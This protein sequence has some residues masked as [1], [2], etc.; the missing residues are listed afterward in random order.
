MNIENHA[1]SGRL[2]R[3]PEVMAELG[4]GLTKVYALI[5]AGSLHAVKLGRRTLV[6]EES[7]AT[8]KAALPKADIRTGRRTAA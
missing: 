2:L 8:F 3:V 6:P 4:I 7:V 5:G 1:A